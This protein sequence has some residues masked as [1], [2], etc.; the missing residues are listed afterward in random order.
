MT[1]MAPSTSHKTALDAGARE[2][3]APMDMPGGRFSIVGDPQGAAFG[4]ISI[5]E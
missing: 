1:D 3:V 2:M 5:A 4:L